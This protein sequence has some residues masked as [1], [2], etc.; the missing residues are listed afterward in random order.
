[1]GKL[2]PLVL[3]RIACFPQRVRFPGGRARFH[4]SISS[5]CYVVF[6]KSRARMSFLVPEENLVSGPNFLKK[7]K[8]IL[9]QNCGFHQAISTDGFF[10]AGKIIKLYGL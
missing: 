5:K 4:N 6:Q 3:F 7:R 9:L 2:S 8:P 10:A 1:M